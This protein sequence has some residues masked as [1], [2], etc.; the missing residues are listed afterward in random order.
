MADD[1]SVKFGATIGDVVEATNKVREQLKGLQEHVA[2]ISEMFGKL[3]ELIGI[4]FSL[5]AIKR[6]I[7]SMAELGEQT[8][9]TA[10]IFGISTQ[11]VGEL[12]FLASATGGSAQDLVRSLERM[13][14]TLEQAGDK[15]TP[16]ARAIAALGLSA[17]DLVQLSL[18]DMLDQLRDKFENLAPGM[19]RTAIAQALVRGG[20][21]TLLPILSLSR[22]R[23]EELTAG[24]RATGA[25][26]SG[27][28]A[29]A[30]AETHSR[31]QLLQSSFTGIGITIFS[32][33]RPAVDSLVD[34]FRSLVQ[35]FN[36]QIKSSGVVKDL[37]TILTFA[38][39]ILVAAVLTLA[40]SFVILWDTAIGV[41]EGLKAPLVG[42]VSA[43]RQAVAGDFSGALDSIK[44]G[45][46]KVGDV[47]VDTAQRIQGSLTT[48][49]DLIKSLFDLNHAPQPLMA[50]VGPPKPAPKIDFGADGKKIGDATSN[51]KLFNTEQ[52]TASF[53]AE[54]I[55]GA[56]NDWL[57]GTKTLGQAFLE[58]AAQ[59]AEAVVQA[60]IFDTIMTALGLPIGGGGGP[61]GAIIAAILPKHDTGAWQVPYDHAAM[62][63][64][65]EMIIPAGPARAMRDGGASPAAGGNVTVNYAPNIQAMDASGVHAVLQRHVHSIA[66]AVAQAM[67]QNPSLRPSY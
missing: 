21:E 22:E 53:L 27:E 39:D 13:A 59:I 7:E 55:A 25:A 46:V 63:H 18:P 64:K 32:L 8:E 9:R 52:Q 66:G 30:F 51:L 47:A 61:F 48:Y 49:K 37:M 20:A 26:M 11:K 3:G 35:G 60:L 12:N 31:I 23:Y 34:G 33:I 65:D 58:L 16:M 45:F 17:K 62:V 28:L 1:V 56:F 41:I 43:V 44:G 14:L 42:L 5:E 4:A 36:N 40:E 57:N 38:I 15:A 19:G 24:F 67:N 10:N 50:G 2:G 54:G 6:F 29:G